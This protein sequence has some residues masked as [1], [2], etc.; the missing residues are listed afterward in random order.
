LQ[1]RIPKSGFRSHLHR[2]VAELRLHELQAAAAH[3][4]GTVD[5]DALKRA[6]LVGITS[7]GVRVIR[8]GKARSGRRSC[9][10]SS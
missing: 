4:K 3:A 8:S 9:G 10:A 6:G 7:S 2:S 5:V 1:R